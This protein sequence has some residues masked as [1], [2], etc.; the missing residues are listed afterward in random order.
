M[1]R[2]RVRCPDLDHRRLRF[3]ADFHVKTNTVVTRDFEVEAVFVTL[4]FRNQRQFLF[5]SLSSTIGP[6][7]PATARRTLS[8]C[9]QQTPP[10]QHRPGSLAA[11]PPSTLHLSS[12]AAPPPP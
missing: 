4:R 1:W 12:P 9:F 7:S 6:P 11:A 2:T 8:R 5:T 10:D 3:A